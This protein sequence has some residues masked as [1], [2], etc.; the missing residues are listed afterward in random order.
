YYQP[1]AWSETKK[2]DDVLLAALSKATGEEATFLAREF[3]RHRIKLGDATEK[4]IALADKD[5]SLLPSL[6]AQL[7]QED[8]IPANAVPL[9]IKAATADSIPDAGR[10]QAVQALTRTDS[11][12]AWLAILSA[13]SKV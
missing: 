11:S 8:T 1:E 12:E 13:M 5:A 10:A 7:A 4:L 6:A 2:I 9:L 3:S